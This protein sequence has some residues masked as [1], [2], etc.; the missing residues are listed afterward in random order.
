MASLAEAA[1]EV[2]PD[3]TLVP[4]KGASSTSLEGPPLAAVN[5]SSTSQEG[6]PLAVV[7]G[8]MKRDASNASDNPLDP[9]DPV[10]PEFA[11]EEGEGAPKEVE[12]RWF[13]SIISESR[14]ASAAEAASNHSETLVD[15][16]AREVLVD[17]QAKEVPP[18]LMP[19]EA[20]APKGKAAASNTLKKTGKAD[21]KAAKVRHGCKLR[22]GCFV[23]HQRPC[24]PH[25]V[26]VLD[27]TMT[28]AVG[29]INT[30]LL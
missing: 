17:D 11:G 1:G 25:K 13:E 28:L 8:T 2:A 26:V 21:T 9:L 3:D 10:D 18:P 19:T 22:A 30:M 6:P 4:S 29:N 14:R 20:I 7:N 15:G 24:E 16:Q 5:G 27:N 12:E 23:V